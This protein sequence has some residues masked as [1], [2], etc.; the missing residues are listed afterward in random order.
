MQSVDISPLEQ[1]FVDKNKHIKKNIAVEFETLCSSNNKD[2]SSD[3]KENFHE[4][5]KS[6]TNTFPQNLYRTI[7]NIYNVLKHLKRNKDIVLL[8]GDKDSSVAILDKSPVVILDQIS[9]QDIWSA[10]W[11]AMNMQ[12]FTDIKQLSINDLKFCPV[13]GQT[14]THLL[15]IQK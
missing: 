1:W 3:D 13:I 4:L 2:I 14:G 6:A 9:Y 5:L 10:H 8:S 7:N 12:K 15:T 11:T